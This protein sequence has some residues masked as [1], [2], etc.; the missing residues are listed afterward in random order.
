[1]GGDSPQA[2]LAAASAEGK[3]RVVT[4]VMNR[5]E[6]K[7]SS[8][9]ERSKSSAKRPRSRSS[10]PK[11]TRPKPADSSATA[12]VPVLDSS[13]S[14]SRS[15]SQSG[16]APSLAP[17]PA[18]APSSSS[19][20]R[21]SGR[22]AR[23]PSR[24]AKED[25]NQGPAKSSTKRR[26]TQSDSENDERDKPLAEDDDALLTQEDTMTGEVK[27]REIATHS[28]SEDEP[29]SAILADIEEGDLAIVP[30]HQP[31]PSWIIVEVLEHRDNNQTHV[32]WWQPR[33]FANETLPADW[34]TVPWQLSLH[35]KTGK[36]WE[37]DLPSG[38]AV[39]ACDFQLAADGRIPPKIVRMVDADPRFGTIVE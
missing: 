29:S 5:K 27:T 22:V 16:P 24:F 15:C 25:G 39:G 20:L 9:K 11:S 17:A 30:W 12:E 37:D 34:R 38:L 32:R 1:M 8:N 7:R 33:G 18:L 4:A 28:D 35:P 2:R 31:N 13:S 36:K 19:V 21:R 3:E 26:R 14:R 10:K 6:V 23:P